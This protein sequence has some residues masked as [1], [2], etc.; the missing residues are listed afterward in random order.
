MRALERVLSRVKR[1]FGPKEKVVKRYAL[2]PVS[3]G[4]A[5][6]AAPGYKTV[7]DVVVRLDDLILSVRRKIDVDVPFEVSVVVPRAEVTE[8]YSEGKMVQRTLVYS[9]ITIAYSPRF[10]GTPRTL[11]QQS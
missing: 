1:V 5:K 9:S 6:P 8:T 2:P 7:D 10:E 4:D 11:R 3:V